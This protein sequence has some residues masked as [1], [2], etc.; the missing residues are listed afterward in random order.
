MLYQQYKKHIAAFFLY[1]LLAFSL[2]APEGASNQIMPTSQDFGPSVGLITQSALAIQEGQFPIR[3]APVEHASQGYPVFQ[4]YAPSIYTIAGYVHVYLSPKN[5]YIAY[6]IMVFF[7]F[8]IGAFFIYRLCFKLTQHFSAAFLSGFAY[9][10]APYFLID[11]H[12][13]GA[14][15]ETMSLGIIPIVVYYTYFLFKE[16]F[17]STHYFLMTLLA[18][19][20]LITTHLI[21]FINTSLLLALFL[22]LLTNLTDRQA[23]GC[24][25]RRLCRVGIAYGWACLIAAWFLAPIF[26]EAHYFN[27]GKSSFSSDF[28][29]KNNWLTSLPRLLSMTAM[30]PML[31]PPLQVMQNPYLPPFYPAVGW[32]ILMSTILCVCALCA[33]KI[34]DKARR[35]FVIK[36]VIVFFIA[37]FFAWSPIDFWQYFPKK[38]IIVQYSYRFLSQVMW[39][40]ALLLGFA[41]TILLAECRQKIS[42]MLIIFLGIWMLGISSESWL[43]ASYTKTR[44]V[45]SVIE[46]PVTGYGRHDGS[47]YL[48]RYEEGKENKISLVSPELAPLCQRIKAVI[49]CHFSSDFSGGNVQLPALYYPD[50]MLRVTSNQHEIPYFSIFTQNKVTLV[51]V[52][53]S[54]GAQD[55]RIQFI[56]C[57]WANYLSCT[58]LFLLMFCGVCFF[59]K[60]R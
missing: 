1:C 35:G 9:M 39:S 47:D 17:F 27:V 32:P 44:P 43:M 42:H 14:F 7:A 56:G 54:S 18:W 46:A 51:G 40:G 22:M 6:K 30:T 4:F 16:N 19:Y 59:V 11:A 58:G 52:S 33:K 8:L 3:T 29:M 36:L 28:I 5:P 23:I 50:N 24:S 13:R 38:M 15:A 60:N 41:V 21:N 26:F 37:L 12:A 45:T 10:V 34:P 49:T 55:I 20:L 53:L 25:I 48:M 2:L 31:F 57:T